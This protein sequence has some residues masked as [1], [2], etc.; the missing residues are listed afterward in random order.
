M[1]DDQLKMLPVYQTFHVL[2]NFFRPL[3]KGHL[4]QKQSGSLDT[5]IRKV[6]LAHIPEVVNLRCQHDLRISLFLGIKL[7][8]DHT[9]GLIPSSQEML[10]GHL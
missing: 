9:P 4:Q 3:G 5:E 8:F 10:H 1:G 7:V 6:C 2:V